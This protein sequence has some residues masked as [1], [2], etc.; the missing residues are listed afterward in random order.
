[1]EKDNFN[2]LCFVRDTKKEFKPIHSISEGK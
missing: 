2:D 1:M